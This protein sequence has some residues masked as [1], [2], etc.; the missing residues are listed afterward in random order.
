[1]EAM[2]AFYKGIESDTKQEEDSKKLFAAPDPEYIDKRSVYAPEGDFEVI[3]HGSQLSGNQGWLSIITSN[4]DAETRLLSTIQP[5]GTFGK[6]EKE[7]RLKNI[8]VSPDKIAF[9]TVSVNGVS[10]EFAG[11]VSNRFYYEDYG[12]HVLTGVLKQRK[13]GVVVQENLVVFEQMEGC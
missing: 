4:Y 11:H 13:N 10:Y 8:L 3:S 2:N 9:T 7:Y 5:K 6:G 1:M 12:H